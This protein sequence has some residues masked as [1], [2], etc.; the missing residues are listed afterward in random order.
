LVYF[1]V[2]ALRDNC[3]KRQSNKKSLNFISN[4]FEANL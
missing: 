3:P 2:C 4:L 1:S